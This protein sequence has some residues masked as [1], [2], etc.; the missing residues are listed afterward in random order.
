MK[1]QR[2]WRGWLRAI[3]EVVPL[4]PTK[5]DTWFNKL[6]KAGAALEA[7]LDELEYHTPLIAEVQRVA[8]CTSLLRLDSPLFQYL[9]RTYNLGAGFERKVHVLSGDRE[10]WVY[11]K[12][13]ECLVQVTHPTTSG[14][15]DIVF[16]TPGFPMRALFAP[17]WAAHPEGIQFDGFFDNQTP[18]SS[19]PPHLG[20]MESRAV[21]LTPS[22]QRLLERL[23]SIP[24]RRTYLAL[25]HYGTGKTTLM[26]MLAKRRGERYLKFGVE[27]LQNMS[28]KHV[29][30]FIDVLAPHFVIVDDFDRLQ[31][32]HLIALLLD[33]LEMFQDEARPTL[34]ITVNS[35]ETL[36]RALLRAGRIDE[37]LDFELPSQEDRQW[38]LHR[39]LPK[40]TPEEHV[41]LLDATEGFSPAEILNLCKNCEFQHLEE[42]LRTTLRLRQLTQLSSQRTESSE[43]Q[44][45][46]AV[47]G[48]LVLHGKRPPRRKRYGR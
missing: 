6:L 17:F 8:E 27:A 34:G 38:L 32:G 3:S 43:D 30:F 44:S 10:L 5:D 11:R 47:E 29:H 28:R 40:L 46:R 45:A 21:E 1:F 24:T 20:K 18:E 31:R 4:L 15:N 22:A 19:S 7:V 48:R 9:F 2:N 39:Y 23:V 12:D 35:T 26:H 16:Y 14:L 41:R 25:G 37:V 13:R 42:A 33:L 36:D